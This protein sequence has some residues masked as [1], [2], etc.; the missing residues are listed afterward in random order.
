VFEALLEN[1][2]PRVQGGQF[3][4]ST[5]FV[6][7]VFLPDLADNSRYTGSFVEKLARLGRQMHDG[8]TPKLEVID[9]LAAQAYG[10]P[11]DWLVEGSVS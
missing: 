3:N 10:M 8:R 2:C 5:R 9:G 4:L 1:A 7:G 11:V 6:N